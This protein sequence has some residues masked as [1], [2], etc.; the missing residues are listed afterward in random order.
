VGLFLL[1]AIPIYFIG[2]LIGLIR[3]QNDAEAPVD[4][5]KGWSRWAPWLAFLAALLLLAFVGLLGAAMW[6]TLAANQNMLLLGALP[7]AWRPIF[8]LPLAFIVLAVAMV[9]AAI[10]LW[11]GHR[12]SMGGRIYYVL[13]TLA[14]LSS[15]LALYRL[16]ILGLGL[17]T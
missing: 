4:W 5:T 1:T 6:M 17:I 16:G 12:R 14:A 11:A 10:A 8:A 3:K 13:L 7:S 15:V 2:W 9:V